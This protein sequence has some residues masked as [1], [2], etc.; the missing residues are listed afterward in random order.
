MRGAR[1]FVQHSVT[2]STGDS[3]GTPVAVLE[4]GAMG[5]PVVATRHAGIPDVVIEGE[6]GLLVDERDAVGM[7]AHMIS[8]ARDPGTANRL[9]REAAARI[10]KFYT[11]DQSIS[12]LSR[13][14]EAAATGKDVRVIRMQI[15]AELPSHKTS[16]NAATPVCKV[17]NQESASHA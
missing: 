14:L 9:G 7:A 3:E 12:R 2:D 4:A 17:M 8:L 11:M 5:L 15:E 1:C 16:D 6:T 10:R 13:I